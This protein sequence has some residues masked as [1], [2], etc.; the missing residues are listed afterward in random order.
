[1]ETTALGFLYG[2]TLVLIAVGVLVAVCRL[3]STPD[4]HTDHDADHDADHD[5]DADGGADGGT[6]H[7]GGDRRAD[8]F[9][10][11]VAVATVP[12]ERAERLRATLIGS[13]VRATLAPARPV[14][15]PVSPR[16]DLL[17]L[18]GELQHVLVFAADLPRAVHALA[19]SRREPTDGA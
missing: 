4:A 10:L 1:M 7:P 15:A 8:D 16:G 5:P 3:T 17:Y 19:Q 11:L 12:S 18:A 2:P 6:G 9:G 13:G 14:P